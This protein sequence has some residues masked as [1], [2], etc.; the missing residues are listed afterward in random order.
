MMDEVQVG[1]DIQAIGEELPVPCE[2][3][4]GKAGSGKTYEVLRRVAE[5]P[6]Y[7]LVCATTGIAAVNLGAVT[8]NSTLKYFDTLSMRDAYLGG[9]LTRLLHKIAKEKRRIII[10]EGSMLEAEQL[11]YLYRAVQEANRYEDVKK[12][13]GIVVVGDFAQLPPVKG[14]WAFT[15]PYWGEFA[16]N[17][18][19]LDKVWRQDEGVFLDALN[20]AR[21]GDGGGCAGL[22][23]D[24]VQ[25][26]TSRDM[27]FEGTTILCK[28]DMVSRHNDVV[29]DRVPGPRFKV[30]S[31]RWGKQRSEWG[32]NKRTHEWGVPPA[33]EFKLGAYVM[34]LSNTKNFEMVNGD[35]GWVRQYDPESE[36]FTVE[37][38]RTKKEVVVGRI[39]REVTDTNEPEGWDG[40]ELDRDDEV[41]WWPKPHYRAKDKKY[42]LGQIRY[43]PLRLAYASTV[44]KVQGLTLDRVQLDFRDKFFESCAMI[45]VGLT[46]CRTLEGLRLVGG[47]DVLAQK[48]KADGRVMPWL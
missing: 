16:Q 21:V 38:I 42:V 31:E 41:G 47:P 23:Y 36:Q 40:K 19:R 30:T 9:H 15:S 26:N 34:V 11:G 3:L 46:R 24:K 6:S 22:L 32:E 5:D 33:A 2:F 12:P 1:T 18:T 28:N 4:T 48:C 14:A 39:V 10:D 45:Y 35:C 20:L 7:G 27:D 37:L 44:H 29:L 43:F 8:I 25:W 17:T 13:L